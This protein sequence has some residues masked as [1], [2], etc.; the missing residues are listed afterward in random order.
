[1]HF[2][3]FY[4][5]AYICAMI[6]LESIYWIFYGLP[7]ADYKCVVYSS[8]LTNY[9]SETTDYATIDE[10]K[11]YRKCKK[12]VEIHAIYQQGYTWQGK[13]MNIV[14]PHW[15]TSLNVAI[16]YC[17]H[18]CCGY[19][20]LGMTRWQK[21]KRACFHYGI[22]SVLHRERK[23]WRQVQGFGIE[24]RAGLFVNLPAESPVK[25]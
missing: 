18:M 11:K 14:S 3:Y 22:C 9:S 1:M 12:W 7:A 10:G 2:L 8:P 17:F 4:I 20:A 25:S 5:C 24:Q 6:Y 21:T 23:R 13:Q 16:S 15:K 19:Q